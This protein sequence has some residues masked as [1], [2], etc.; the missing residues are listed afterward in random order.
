MLHSEMPK[1][2]QD[3][4]ISPPKQTFKGPFALLCV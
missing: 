4:A 3:K 1:L 2:T